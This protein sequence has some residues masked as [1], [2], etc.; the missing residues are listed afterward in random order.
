MS[1]QFW[2]LDD[3][4]L[5]KR[6]DIDEKNSISWQLHMHSD[7]KNQFCKKLV[8]ANFFK[9]LVFR[10]SLFFRKSRFLTF[11]NCFCTAGD[12]WISLKLSEILVQSMIKT[13]LYISKGTR[14]PH[15]LHLML[16]KSNFLHFLSTLVAL[17]FF[18]APTAEALNSA[19]PKLRMEYIVLSKS[20]NLSI[21]KGLWEL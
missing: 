21:H 5:K 19:C 12:N 1:H 11:L 7:S 6:D 2:V 14:C 3:W 15:L 13:T 16:K 17:T 18:T 8:Y 10:K 20:F 9:K 4:N